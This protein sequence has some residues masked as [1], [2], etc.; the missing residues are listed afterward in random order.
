MIGIDQIA[1]IRLVGA[2]DQFGQHAEAV[3][4]VV[5]RIEFDGEPQFVFGGDVAGLA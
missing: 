4:H 2:L 1:T 3:E 5:L